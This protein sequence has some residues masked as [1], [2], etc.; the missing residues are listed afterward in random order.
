MIGGSLDRMVRSLRLILFLFL[1]SVTASLFP[2]S[3]IVDATTAEDAEAQIVL[4]QRSAKWLPGPGGSLEDEVAWTAWVTEDSE[5]SIVA[6]EFAAPIRRMR[7]KHTAQ[8]GITGL[9]LESTTGEVA[10]LGSAGGHWNKWLPV[11]E[12]YCQIR[13]SARQGSF[14]LNARVCG[15]DS[16]ADEPVTSGNILHCNKIYGIQARVESEHQGLTNFSAIMRPSHASRESV[17]T[18]F[19]ARET[20]VARTRRE[21]RCNECNENL[22]SLVQQQISC[23]KALDAEGSPAA[24]R[25]QRY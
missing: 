16:D 22:R 3:A 21:A 2:R 13:A 14:L 24:I 25:E 4:L 6:R 1:G 5:G 17:P 12:G 9:E 19:A 23:W 10:S 20:R 15:K 11:N 7:F 18:A 8:V